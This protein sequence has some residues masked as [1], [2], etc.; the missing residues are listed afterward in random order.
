LRGD[1]EIVYWKRLPAM[2]NQVELFPYYVG[3]KIIFGG[4]MKKSYIIIVSLLLLALGALGAQEGK[5]PFLHT[6]WVVELV[7][8]QEPV[9]F[10]F[11]ADGTYKQADSLMYRDLQESHPM[12]YRI[13]VDN[14]LIVLEFEQDFWIEWRYEFGMDGQRYFNLYLSN[15]ENPLAQ[16]F[17]GEFG[18][19]L[20]SNHY[21]EV[22]QDFFDAIVE[23]MKKVILEQPFMQGFEPAG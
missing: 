16:Q 3:R 23:A 19:S 2:P 22:T 11:Y 15:T 21:N 9:M 14:E 10:E 8:G 5:N 7:G 18:Q 12:N 20:E 1:K 17:L 4:S 13:D 6:W